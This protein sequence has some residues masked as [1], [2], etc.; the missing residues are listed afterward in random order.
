VKI[1]KDREAVASNEDGERGTAGEAR[2]PKAARNINKV[3]VW[4]ISITITTFFLSALFTVITEITTSTAHVAAAFMLLILLIAINIVLDAIGVAA[5]SCELAPLLSMASRKVKGSRMAIK[6][7]KNAEKVS[8]ICCD[9]IGDICGIVSGSCTLSIVISLTVNAPGSLSFW[10]SVL[11]SSV[12]AALTV[13]GKAIFKSLAIKHSKEII[14]M[15]SRML[16]VF[17]RKQK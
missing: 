8:N 3:T 11:L 9:V 13:G 7:V 10:V 16:S 12:V 17:E 5:T 1:K 2:K 15:V 4:T 6:L 14:L